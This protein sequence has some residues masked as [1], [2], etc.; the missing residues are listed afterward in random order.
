MILEITERDPRALG[1]RSTIWTANL[2]RYYLEEQHHLCVSR[3]NVTLATARLGLRWKRPQHGLARRLAT[4]RQ[5]KGAQEYL[6][7]TGGHRHLDAR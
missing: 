4:W 6:G 7:R 1:C 2:L 5:A 3:K